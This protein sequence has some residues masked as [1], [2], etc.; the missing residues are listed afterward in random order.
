MLS[1]DV[2]AGA[3]GSGIMVSSLCGYLVTPHFLAILGISVWLIYTLDHLLDARRLK[4]S[5]STLR[6]RFHHLYFKYIVLAWILL[7]L[8][9]AILVFC[10][11]ELS[12]IYFGLIMFGFAMAH[13]SLV[14]LVGN[15]TSPLLI[16]EMG[17]AVVYSGGIWGLPVLE[18]GN[19]IQP[20]IWVSFFQFLLLAFINLLLFSYFEYETD[21]QDK[22]TSYVRAIGKVAARNFTGAL[23]FLLPI[24]ELLI[25]IL[26]PESEHFLRV[27]SIYLLMWGILAALWVFPVWFKQYER[28]RKWGDG[29]FLIPFLSLF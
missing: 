5:A 25:W 17:V 9:G 2:V 10:R 7:A 27:G 28:Y 24:S 26:I 21:E 3:L 20:V 11:L 8:A 29:A 18:T 19:W 16:K 15:Q 1:L 22:H 14:R 23:L 12:A 6:H 13:L 4:G